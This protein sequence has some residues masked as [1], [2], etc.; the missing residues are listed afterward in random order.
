[1]SQQAHQ[2][3][4]CLWTWTM[5]ETKWTIKESKWTMSGEMTGAVNSK[6]VN[7][8]NTAGV[9]LFFDKKKNLVDFL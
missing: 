4:V 3:A 6:S 2:R 1:M 9:E 8:V 7:W 5:K